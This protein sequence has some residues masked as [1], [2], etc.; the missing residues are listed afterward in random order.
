MGENPV[1]RKHAVPCPKRQMG[2]VNCHDVH[3]R[4]GGGVSGQVCSWVITGTLLRYGRS[5]T[6]MPQRWHP[7]DG[8]VDRAC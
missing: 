8:E 1:E 4:D 7:R 2:T 5:E 3:L 6:G